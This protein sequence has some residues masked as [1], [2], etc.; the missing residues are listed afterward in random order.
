MES[1]VTVSV[2]VGG[3][4]LVVQYLA[5]FERRL[6][7]LGTEQ[8]RNLSTV[9]AATRLYEQVEMSPIEV[10]DLKRLV[11]SM[12]TIRNLGIRM[13]SGLVSAE[14]ER[15]AQFVEQIRVGEATYEGEDREWLLGL[16]RTAQGEIAAT[17]STLVDDGFWETELGDRYLKAQGEAVDRGVRV[18]R[19]FIVDD[20]SR[21]SGQSFNALL[22]Q[23]MGL[24]VEVRAVVFTDLSAIQRNSY[25]D[26]VV[27]DKRVYY[28]VQAPPRIGTVSSPAAV[29]ET[30]LSARTEDVDWAMVSFEELWELAGEVP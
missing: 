7:S 20:H 11:E 23:Q 29:V 28:Q 2:L 26:F 8:R 30:R 19:L 22:R 12:T 25:R 6:D 24:K 4:V 9:N 3:A 17:S 1:T 5:G 21:T 10:E 27:F 16:T 13:I 15:F 18:R 14:F